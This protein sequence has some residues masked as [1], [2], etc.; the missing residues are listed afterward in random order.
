MLKQTSLFA[1][2]ATCCGLAFAP[3]ASAEVVHRAVFEP[4]VNFGWPEI[5]FD[6]DNAHEVSF[7]FY[8]IGHESGG[9]FFLAAYSS[10]NTELLLQSGRV[11]PLNWG[12]SISSTSTPGQWAGT[13]FGS[14]VWTMGFSAQPPI[15]VFPPG[16]ISTNS[17]PQPPPGVFP[18]A[19]ILTNLPPQS[20]RGQGVGVPGYGSFFAAR[21][22]LADGWRY[23][24]VR[25]GV[26]PGGFLTLPGILDYAYETQPDTAI[27][28]GAG[29]D[30]DN[31]DVWDLSDECSDTPPGEAVNA[32]GCSISQL[33]PCDGPWKNHGEYLARVI[34][35]VAQ[36]QR[37]RLIRPAE[38]RAIVREAARS[39]C[40]KRP[41]PR[42]HQGRFDRERE[43]HAEDHTRTS[44][45]R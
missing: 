45:T 17:L 24:W 11:L 37:Q 30:S 4:G 1:I 20:P 28:A 34:A 27:L 22:L 25:M 43:N 38:A 15:V 32:D 44:Q 33:V 23:G 35:T 3:V 29:I 41:T 14:T 26:P 16:V 18:L 6:G 9:A 39:D 40:G 5:D 2:L 8:A 10:T 21:F 36:F 42:P 13:E 7:D 31:D 12:D 19:T